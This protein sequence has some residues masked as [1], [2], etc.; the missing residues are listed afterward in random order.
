MEI[1]EILRAANEAVQEADLP[2]ELK[3]V[4]FQSA[5]DLIAAGAGS[6]TSDG[7]HSRNE[8]TSTTLGRIASKLNLPL[9]V[10]QDVY[11]DDGDDV[12]IGVASSALPS[13]KAAATKQLARLVAVGQQAGGLAEWTPVDQIRRVCVDFGRHDD[14]NFAATIQEMGDEFQIRGSRRQREVRVKRPALERAADLIQ[15]LA[16]HN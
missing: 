13:R 2:A 1:V 14:S 11:F 12:G 5:I 10:V 3:P 16:G 4:A 15:Q 9:E 7:A 6:A 8:E